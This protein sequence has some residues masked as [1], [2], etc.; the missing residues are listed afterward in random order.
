MSN[1]SKARKFKSA[2]FKVFTA[3]EGN[4]GLLDLL[5]VATS[6]GRMTAFMVALLDFLPGPTVFDRYDKK[7]EDLCNLLTAWFRDYSDFTTHFSGINAALQDRQRYVLETRFKKRHFI[8]AI[9]LDWTAD[10]KSTFFSQVNP[11]CDVVGK[12]SFLS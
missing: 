9:G 4:P 8:T 11:I 2:V 1:T 6:T 10:A 3:L 5:E 12:F 7:P